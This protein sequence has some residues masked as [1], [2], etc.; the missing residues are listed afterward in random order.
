MVRVLTKKTNFPT[1]KKGRS[2]VCT[3][4]KTSIKTSLH[5]YLHDNCKGKLKWFLYLHAMI[6]E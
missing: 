1:F 6:V 5:S 2:I 4:M 3:D